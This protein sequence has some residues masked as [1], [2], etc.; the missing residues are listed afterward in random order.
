M[1]WWPRSHTHQNN[2]WSRPPDSGISI[3]YVVENVFVNHGSYDKFL[4]YT[5]TFIGRIVGISAW[6]VICTWTNAW[7]YHRDAR[8]LGRH[9]AHSDVTI[10]SHWVYVQHNQ[11]RKS[12]R[13]ASDFHLYWEHIIGSPIQIVY[14][15]IQWKKETHHP[16]VNLWKYHYDNYSTTET[17]TTHKNAAVAVFYR[18]SHA[19]SPVVLITFHFWTRD[20]FHNFYGLIMEMWW[21]SVSLLFD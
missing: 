12:V 13:R 8:D 7:A 9:R 4:T 3:G 15:N 17:N 5:L 20:P 2:I 21:N 1:F 14:T 19:S 6:N 11:G 18:L 10:M 16:Y